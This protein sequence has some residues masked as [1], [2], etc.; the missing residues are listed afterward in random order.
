MI[1]RIRRVETRGRCCACI[2]E[3]E[4]PAHHAAARTTRPERRHRSTVQSRLW[5]RTS[6]QARR[7]SLVT[8]YSPPMPEK[9]PESAPPDRTCRAVKLLGAQGKTSIYTRCRDSAIRN[10]LVARHARANRSRTPVTSKFS[11]A[12]HLVP[13]E[14]PHEANPLVL[15]FLRDL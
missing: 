11:G 5:H 10:P 4:A 15:D 12:A 1:H 8:A 6:V 3:N 2:R 14:A 13:L 7:R 9:S